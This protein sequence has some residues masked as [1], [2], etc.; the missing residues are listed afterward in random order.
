MT[1]DKDNV[2]AVI[3]RLP[4][5]AQVLLAADVVNAFGAGLVMPFLLIYLSQV[6]HLN[7]RVAAA[8]LSVSAIVSFVAGLAWG[9]L[10]D[11]Y[12]HRAIMPAVMLV[13]AVGSSLYAI[14]GTPWT[15][16]AISALYGAGIGGVGPVVR[17]MIAT[18][19]SPRER[20]QF[21]GLQFGIF[22][23]SIGLGILAGGLLVNGSLGRYQLLYGGDGIT[24]VF[25]A[26]A[27]LVF[28]PGGAT[29]TSADEEGDERAAGRARASYRSMLSNPAV[30]L[31]MV[32][33]TLGATFY[34]GEF[35][36]ALP[37]YLTIA[38]AVSPRGISGAFVINVVVVVLTQFLV[39]PRLRR[40]R[41]TTWLTV[42]G[43]L[44]G[45]SWLLVLWA[46]RTGGATALVLLFTAS[47][48]FAVA[49]VMVTPI[50]VALL[51]DIVPDQVRGRANALFTFSI[52]GGM[53]LGP[54]VTA[55]LLPVGKGVPL[56]AGLAAGCLLMLIPAAMLRGRLRGDV[57]KPSEAA[58]PAAAEAA[59]AGS[60]DRS[61]SV[62][63]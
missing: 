41:R 1:A 12:S 49:E 22:N 24:F 20:T 11:R 13:A 3:A 29:E 18:V 9:T 31:I 6:R 23:A 60:G 14:A 21:F 56:V 55:A 25:M 34:Y 61:Q 39:M 47:V 35:Q 45:L 52:T 57:D 43:L 19:V 5:R 32:A 7:I 42:S 16:L 48:P 17:T 27:L 58:E 33:M 62:P 8:A 37:G 15:A 54:A 50:L 63:A 4:R 36:S 30:I 46:G 28:V 38:H 10:L 2:V 53:I 40:V 44:W 26:I 59:S 51:N